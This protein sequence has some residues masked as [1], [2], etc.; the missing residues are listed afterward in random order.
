MSA[1]WWW[2]SRTVGRPM[3]APRHPLLSTPRD[4]AGRPSSHRHPAPSQFCQP[5][6][7]RLSPKTWLAA[8]KL[9]LLCRLLPLPL[10]WP[11]VSPSAC[12]AL[13]QRRVKGGT[14][15][16]VVFLDPPRPPSYLPVFVVI[17]GSS[18]ADSIVFIYQTPDTC[19]TSLDSGSLSSP[20]R[21]V[22]LT[23]TLSPSL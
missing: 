4:H 10:H 16:V 6:S 8:D 20:L 22:Q 21:L 3:P 11:P 13:R 18:L 15:V 23:G 9:S 1:P 19:G 12:P 14:V 2:P 5:L 7:C 17:A